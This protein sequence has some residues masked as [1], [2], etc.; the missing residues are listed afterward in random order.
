MHCHVRES[1]RTGQRNRDRRHMHTHT[2]RLSYAN[3][4]PEWTRSSLLSQSVREMFVPYA[5]ALSIHE[6]W[7]TRAR[8]LLLQA[9]VAKSLYATL[10][11]EPTMVCTCR[12]SMIFAMDPDLVERVYV[13][14]ILHD[15]YIRPKF[16]VHR[17]IALHALSQ[18][19][20]IWGFSS[21]FPT[22]KHEPHSTTTYASNYVCDASWLSPRMFWLGI[23]CYSRRSL[24]SQT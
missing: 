1:Q 17:R 24:L 18:H 12:E 15:Y 16:A 11:F 9:I 8:A 5:V 20:I 21:C 4:A 13:F 10:A 2:R 7:L 23:Q 19:I 22:M 6:W 14:I 3:R